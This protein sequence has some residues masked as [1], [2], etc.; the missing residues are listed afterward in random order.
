M[1]RRYLTFIG[2]SYSSLIDISS[3]ALSEVHRIND[4]MVE[5]GLT[6]EERRGRGPRRPQR[7]YT[8][9]FVTERKVRDVH[10]NMVTGLMTLHT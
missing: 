7:P 3:Q 5:L 6:A 9:I 10:V 8:L 2:T 4:E 1:D